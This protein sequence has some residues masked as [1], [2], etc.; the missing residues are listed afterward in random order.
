MGNMQI[1]SIQSLTIHIRKGDFVTTAVPPNEP[2]FVLPG[3][4]TLA[5]LGPSWDFT[6]CR[7]RDSRLHASCDILQGLAAS[8]S[9]VES[10]S[11]LLASIGLTDQVGVSML[12]PPRWEPH[13]DPIGQQVV[14]QMDP[15]PACKW[16]RRLSTKYLDT[17]TA[18]RQLY[19]R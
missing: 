6:P 12:A 4:S 5:L 17:T 16:K 13:S 11:P 1:T 8:S 10:S 19:H 14:V 3:V 9:S 15:D 2:M 7:A 18:I